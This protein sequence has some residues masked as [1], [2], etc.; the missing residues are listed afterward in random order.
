MTRQ[1]KNL[2][3]EAHVPAEELSDTDLEKATGGSGKSDTPT[4]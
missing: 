2:E 4:S 3:T 1:H